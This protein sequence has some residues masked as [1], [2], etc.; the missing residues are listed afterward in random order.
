MF[1]AFCVISDI[2]FVCNQAKLM[3]ALLKKTQETA[4][5]ELQKQEADS[6]EESTHGRS[7]D[8][9]FGRGALSHGC[10]GIA[11]VYVCARNSKLACQR[12]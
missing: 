4:R 10:G 5:A 6:I 8:G 1:V 11:G 12:P 2:E 9:A 7:E 3:E